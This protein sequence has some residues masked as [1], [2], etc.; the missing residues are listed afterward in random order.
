MLLTAVA[1]AVTTT[2]TESESEGGPPGVEKVQTRNGD[3]PQAGPVYQVTETRLYGIVCTVLLSTKKK[4]F[5]GE[6]MILHFGAVISE[7]YCAKNR[8]RK[9]P[10]HKVNQSASDLDLLEFVHVHSTDC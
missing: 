3:V 4:F 10:S 6:C 2:T 8:E 1:E 7:R 5:F 9:L